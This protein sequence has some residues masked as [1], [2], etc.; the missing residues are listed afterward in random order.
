MEKL[1][2]NLELNLKITIENRETLAIW[3]TREQTESTNTIGLRWS[4]RI[5]STEDKDYKSERI[6]ENWNE[7]G[8]LR[9]FSRKCKGKR[10]QGG[11]HC[12]SNTMLVNMASMEIGR[13]KLQHFALMIT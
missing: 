13:E 10:F 8:N 9:K 5:K 12:C 1:V 4:L 6:K 7:N 3:G 2:T 11:Y